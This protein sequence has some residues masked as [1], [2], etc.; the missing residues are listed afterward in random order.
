M[1][2]LLHIPYLMGAITADVVRDHAVGS[3]SPSIGGL[4]NRAG[5]QHAQPAGHTRNA[6]LLLELS[7]GQ[8]SPTAMSHTLKKILLPS[9]L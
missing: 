5:S 8:E 3:M 9:P 2:I 4:L 1:E 6:E 7:A